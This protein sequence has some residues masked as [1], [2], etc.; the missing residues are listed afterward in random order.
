[1]YIGEAIALVVVSIAG[2]LLTTSFSR[3]VG[4]VVEAL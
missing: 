2:S 4:F 1:M 3:G